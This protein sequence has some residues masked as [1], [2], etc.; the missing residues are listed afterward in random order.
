[1]GKNGAGKSILLKILAGVIQPTQGKVS[2]P[3]D[4]V[5]TYLSQH[6]LNEDKRTVF[7]ESSQ[8]F[9]EVLDMQKEMDELNHQLTVRTDYES[10]E[11]MDIIERVS[12]L[13]ERVYGLG[14]IN[15]DAEVEKILLGLGFV[16]EDFTHP[17]SKL[18]FKA[19]FLI[20]LNQ[21]A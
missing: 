12:T 11:Y 18:L 3:N 1:M 20:L 10:Q 13:G 16:R 17:T 19:A 8:A 14:D 7:E 2:T 6:L 9:E 5:I 21:F 4:A 15:F